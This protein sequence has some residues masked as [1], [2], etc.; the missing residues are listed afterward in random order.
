[1]IRRQLLAVHFEGEERV[2]RQQWQWHAGTVLAF[3]E[4][5]CASEMNVLRFL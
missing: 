3:G 2:G 5:L 1:M 4:V